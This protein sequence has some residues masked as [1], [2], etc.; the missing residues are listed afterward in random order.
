MHPK[1]L[2]AGEHSARSGQ[3]GCATM[4][5][6]QILAATN[7]PP[8]ARVAGRGNGPDF[9]EALARGLDVLRC[10]DARRRRMSLTEVADASDLARPTAR[11]LLL[12]LQELGY[13]RVVDGQFELTPR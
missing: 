10:F 11:R 6:A 13:V 1:S 2:W 8:E 7:D 9:V 12:T 5:A 3:Q 4:L